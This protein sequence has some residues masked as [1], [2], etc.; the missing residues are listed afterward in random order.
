MR[1]EEMRTVSLF[2]VLANPVRYKIIKLLADGEFT[3]ADLA[4]ETDRESQNISQHMRI[5]RQQNLVRH[6]TETNQVYYCLK[7]RE[8][9]KL[10]DLAK[11]FVKRR[12]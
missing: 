5:L 12:R 7:R 4:N 2:K 9:L 10:L 3:V 8:I 1:E 11:D 6:R